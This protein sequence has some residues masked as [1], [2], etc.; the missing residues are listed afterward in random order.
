[1]YDM[2]KLPYAFD[3]LEPYIDE[4]TLRTHYGKHLQTYAN[5]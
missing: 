4:E 5:N 2:I 1:M 3:S